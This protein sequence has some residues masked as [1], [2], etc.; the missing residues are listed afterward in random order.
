[1][2]TDDGN[3]SFPAVVRVFILRPCVLVSARVCSPGFF[4]VYVC[5]CEASL[6][7][8]V[9]RAGTGTSLGQVSC[10]RLSLVCACVSILLN[11]KP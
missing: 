4:T 2:Y 11:P 5:V 1:M 9:H 10:I 8:R 3:N 7:V 6:C